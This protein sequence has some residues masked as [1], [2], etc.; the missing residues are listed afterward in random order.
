MRRLI[1]T[2]VARQMTPLPRR[3]DNRSIVGF[4]GSGGAGKTR[5]V[6]QLALGYARRGAQSLCV[7]SLR[8]SDGGASLRQQLLGC[9]IEVHV[10]RTGRGAR[11]I[12]DAAEEASLVIVDTPAVSPRMLTE[13]RRL[14]ADLQHIGLDECHLVL[15]ATI[16][17]R[18]AAEVVRSARALGV[19][20]I[21]ITHADETQYLGAA[22]SVAILSEIPISYVG[23]AHG[24]QRGLRPALSESLA[25]AL[26]S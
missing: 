10:A 17:Y 13:L 24:N 14:R 8:P 21:V 2:T 5:C 23:R 16:D 9:D 7:V 4:V 22:V 1:A 6:A 15:P 11:A 12:I 3:G 20:A 26:V 18:H 19:D 25:L